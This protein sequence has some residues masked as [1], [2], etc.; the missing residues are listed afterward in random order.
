LEPKLVLIAIAALL[1]AE[2]AAVDVGRGVLLL[3]AR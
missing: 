3:H 1:A 2:A